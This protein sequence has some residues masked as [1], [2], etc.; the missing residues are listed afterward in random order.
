MPRQLKNKRQ[1]RHARVRAKVSGTAARPRLSAFRSNKYVYAQLI[2]DERGIT[3][4]AASSRTVK[5]GA[6]K[7]GEALARAA[8]EKKITQAVFDRGGYRYAGQIKA[9]ADGARTG[10]LNF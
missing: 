10:G 2:D 8:A 4:A 1:I 5:G 9:L 6:A 7:V 3:L